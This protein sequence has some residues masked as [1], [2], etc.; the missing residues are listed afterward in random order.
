MAEEAE[1][2]SEV[3]AYTPAMKMRVSIVGLLR[4]AADT[5]DELHELR[6]N[7]TEYDDVDYSAAEA[8]GLREIADNLENLDANPALIFEWADLYAL[9]GLAAAHFKAA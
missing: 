4:N 6:E 1:Q 7:D 3:P 9:H 8:Y 2:Q 5:L